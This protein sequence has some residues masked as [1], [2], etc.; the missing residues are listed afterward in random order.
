MGLG[1]SESDEGLHYCFLSIAI[2]KE[3]REDMEKRDRKFLPSSVPKTGNKGGQC[4]GGVN[5]WNE[6]I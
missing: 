4:G 6:L 1:C 5:C 3:L 2:E